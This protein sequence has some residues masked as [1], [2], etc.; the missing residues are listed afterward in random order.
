[1]IGRRIRAAALAAHCLVASAAAARADDATEL[2]P[3]QM[4]RSLQLVQDRIANGDQ[5]AL[6]MQRKLLEMIDQRF[7]ETDS[8]DFV[9]ERNYQA[10]LVYAMSGGNPAT[11]DGL[12]A[13]LHLS[14]TDRAL[15]SGIVAYLK[16]DIASARTAL[17]PV[18]PL[19]LSPD[20]GAFFA[21]VKGSVMGSDDPAA[22]L[23]MFDEARLLSPG[24]LVEEAALRRSIALDA[25][26]G[27]APHFLD[28]SDQYVRRFL[29]SPYAS[30]FAD[31]F[32]AAVVALHAG[33]D[34]S[35]VD[36]VI[37]GMDP[38]RQKVIYLR[39]ARRAAIDGISDLSA[40][41]SAKADAIRIGGADSA[42][43]PRT[44]LYSSLASLTSD[45]VD[46][47]MP[48]LR[49]IDPSRL[50]ESDRKLLAAAE[51]IAAEV[52]A[53]PAPAAPAAAS[54][55]EP[56]ASDAPPS[57]AAADAA[58]DDDLPEAEPL[59]ASQAAAAAASAPAST[60]ATD[61]AP[62]AAETAP[63]ENTAAAA[64]PAPAADRPAEAAAVAAAGAPAAGATPA[65]EPIPA[66][67]PT[68]AVLA[69]G[70]KKLDE[71]DKLLKDSEQ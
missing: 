42:S 53:G 2:M 71:I 19:K 65:T 59:D 7:R 30:Q 50:S 31:A 9:D 8:E 61:A 5:A 25:R 14:E 64:P 67:D 48:K 4:V 21:L 49:A 46:T 12:L 18:D 26:S 22:A 32:V 16:G 52:T 3:Y 41:A 35:Q 24:T 40:Y 58:A 1:M 11:I 23:R 13:R 39:L 45:N 70:R 55:G 20:L 28:V 37:A 60:P 38:E 68:A 54:A 6:P 62:T 57:A 15:G 51:A 34:L 56:K 63:A 27:N 29:L 44:L 66:D 10:L 69:D 33:I 36:Q 17:D 47:V 43:D